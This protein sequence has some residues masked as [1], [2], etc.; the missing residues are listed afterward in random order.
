MFFDGVGSIEVSLTLN[1]IDQVYALRT[2][3][4]SCKDRSFDDS[5]K[6]VIQ[7]LKEELLELGVLGV[8][9]DEVNIND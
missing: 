6:F 9:K 1:G 2:P 7:K 3:L 8:Y 4:L 5:A